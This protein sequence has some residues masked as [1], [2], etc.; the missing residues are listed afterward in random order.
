MAPSAAFM[1]SSSVSSMSCANP[2]ANS[3]PWLP[4]S[5]TVAGMP[6]RTARSDSARPEI[7]TATVAG[8]SDSARKASAASGRGRASAGWLTIGARVP[9]KS[10]ATSSRGVCAADRSA[11]DR[12]AGSIESDGGLVGLT[13][14]AEE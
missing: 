6:D 12:S 9:S 3:A 8:S 7:S 14:V 4:T 2:V 13:A 11:A 10:D 5:C 1:V